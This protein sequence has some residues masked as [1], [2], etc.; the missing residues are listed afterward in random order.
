MKNETRH[1]IG[2][3]APEVASALGVSVRLIW[4]EIASRRL[5]HTKIGRKRVV[6]TQ[7]QLDAY[8]ASNETKSFD[9]HAVVRD[10]LG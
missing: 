1:R 3:S 7:E 5:A 6:I 10:V 8:L 9:A 4:S 2:Y